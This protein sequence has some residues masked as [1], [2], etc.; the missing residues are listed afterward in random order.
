MSTVDAIGGIEIRRLVLS[1]ALVLT[2]AAIA[3]GT[4]VLGSGSDPVERERTPLVADLSV[5]NRAQPPLAVA[6]PPAEAG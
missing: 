1:L 6:P 2:V 4:W 3:V 5:P